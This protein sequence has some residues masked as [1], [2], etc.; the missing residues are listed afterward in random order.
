M[1]AAHT[2][3]FKT[4]GAD[5]KSPSSVTVIGGGIS[6]LTIA[7]RL[8][9]RGIVVKLYEAQNRLGG[10]IY[11]QSYVNPDSQFIELGAE[12]IDSTHSD[13]LALAQELGVKTD[14][15][16]AEDSGLKKITL[17]FDGAQH[18]SQDFQRD[19][20]PLFER[21]ISDYDSILKKP[22]SIE[23]LDRLSLTDY[24]DSISGLKKWVKAFIQSAYEG[25]FGL[26]AD[27]LSPMGL[28]TLLGTSTASGSPFGNS[29]ECMR[30]HGG[31]SNL[32]LSLEKK[33]RALGVQIYLNQRLNAIQLEP[34]N[35]LKLEFDFQKISTSDPVV[36]T[37]PL[38]L[39]RTIKGIAQLPLS[40]A[41]R[42]AILALSMGMNSKS[43]MEFKTKF[44]RTE[45]RQTGSLFSDQSIDCL[46]ETSR[47]Q[48]GSRGILTQ[49]LS[50]GRQ[51]PSQSEIP[52]A[53]AKL[54]TVMPGISAQYSRR[55]GAFHWP[56]FK[57]ALGSYTCPKKGQWTTLQSAFEKS[58]D[59]LNLY[60]AGEHCS[61]EFFGFMNGAVESAN[62]VATQ[63]SQSK[64]S[65][66]GSQS[67]YALK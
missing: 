13:L 29:D 66:F 54:E 56:T 9:S 44:W 12:L 61:K 60:F 43:M 53:L 15:F 7:Y 55:L 2:F 5:R 27:E 64:L 26:G 36:M 17:Y 62:R 32:I 48:M 45:L 21:I 46:W 49:F 3:P 39:L 50:Q 25:E 4:F 40:P 65:A 1:I 11:T 47:G 16:R 18:S 22:D 51:P 63:I 52:Q 20:K 28:I 37:L 19:G 6:G 30:I 8:A 38:S 14:D 67:K 34:E 24:L 33:C 42:K 10:R 58:S 35:V 31:N 41:T 23:T 59:G 57:Y